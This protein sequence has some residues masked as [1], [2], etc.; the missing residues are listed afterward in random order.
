MNDYVGNMRHSDWVVVWN[1]TKEESG[2]HMERSLLFRVLFIYFIS[3]LH[4]WLKETAGNAGS[5]PGLGRSS[6][7]GNGNLLQ[8]SSLE[9]SVDR[10]AWQAQL[11]G[12]TESQTQLSN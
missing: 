11:P 6:G 10:G 2:Y 12:V 4:W 5:V 9:S 1:G 3:F 8:N 7:E